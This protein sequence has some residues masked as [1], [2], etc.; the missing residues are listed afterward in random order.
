[1]CCA[2]QNMIADIAGLI[3]DG[4]KAGCALKI[5]TGISAALQCA[6]LA[7]TGGRAGGRDGIVMADVERS[8]ANLG[9]LGARGMLAAD[10]VILEM[11]LCK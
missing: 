11:M 8:I 3:C 5:A 2:V 9:E 6:H 4:A 7:L 10:R 1:M